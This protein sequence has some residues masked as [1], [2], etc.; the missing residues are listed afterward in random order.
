M[1]QHP[2]VLTER[3]VPP[4]G[5]GQGNHLLEDPGSHQRVE[6]ENPAG[7]QEKSEDY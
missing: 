7:R 6:N 2:I 5:G 3:S 1:D 4:T